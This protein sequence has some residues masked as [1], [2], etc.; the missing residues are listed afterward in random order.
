MK[1][2]LDDQREAPAG[3]QQV[4]WPEEAIA[5]LQTGRVTHLSLD[6][7]LGDDRRGT[8]YDV[9]LW[10]EEAVATQGFMPPHIAVHSAN[11]SARQKMEAGIRSIERL[12]G[13]QD[14]N[15][16]N[17]MT[18]ST[19][20]GIITNMD[21]GESLEVEHFL[22]PNNA[23]LSAIAKVGKVASYVHEDDSM[24][25]DV[26]CLA[27]DSIGNVFPLSL[28]YTPEA[29]MLRDAIL[30]DMQPDCLIYISGEFTAGCSPICVHDAEYR[31]VEPKVAEVA[32]ECFRVN[33]IKSQQNEFADDD[34]GPAQ[35]LT[36]VADINNGNDAWQSEKVSRL[37]RDT[38]P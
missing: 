23:V 9:I 36:G 24:Q 35:E 32:R 8:G 17:R 5:L 21:T 26:D 7:D 14:K 1:V 33:A 31:A 38:L 30:E 3:W 15:E 27:L 12:A 10:I 25:I 18:G 4:H 22:F 19:I 11:S 13:K 2:Y 37:C 6:H 16:E 29:V 20:K 28:N 34:R